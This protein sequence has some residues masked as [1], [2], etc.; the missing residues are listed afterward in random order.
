MEE[1]KDDDE[2]IGRRCHRTNRIKLE[3]NTKTY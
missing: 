1:G 3:V 2:Y